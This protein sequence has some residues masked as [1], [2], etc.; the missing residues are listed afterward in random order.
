MG[1]S[2]LIAGY[3]QKNLGPAGLGALTSC[4]TKENIPSG[5]DKDQSTKEIHP[6]TKTPVLRGY[7]HSQD[8]PV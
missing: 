5:N 1:R 4:N 7:S 3:S 2:R 8:A 6:G